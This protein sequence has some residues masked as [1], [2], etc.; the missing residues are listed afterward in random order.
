MHVCV[1][2]SPT[3]EITTI[4]SHSPPCCWQ[5]KAFWAAPLARYALVTI[6]IIQ[7]IHAAPDVAKIQLVRRRYYV[8]LRNFHLDFARRCHPTIIYS[9]QAATRVMCAHTRGDWRISSRWANSR[10]EVLLLREIWARSEKL[11][12][13]FGCE[14]Y[15]IHFAAVSACNLIRNFANF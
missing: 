2:V 3:P 13:L 6:H 4:I 12:E 9:A 15:I 10:N 5:P 7:N 14:L 8:W 11:H 1:C